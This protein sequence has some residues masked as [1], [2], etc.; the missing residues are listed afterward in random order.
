[1]TNL[2][3]IRQA[4]IKANPEIMELKFGCRIKTENMVKDYIKVICEPFKDSEKNEYIYATHGQTAEKIYLKPY[5]TENKIIK[6]LG[7]EIRLSDVLLA[8]EKL[9]EDR[10]SYWG[11][12]S[13]GEFIKFKRYDI[14]ENS[15]IFWDLKNDNL[16][17]QSE[18][19]I[20]FLVELLK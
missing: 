10:K 6:I 18:E 20:N 9:N 8:L 7:R 16:E 5:K 2:E 4:C 19:T 17:L 14:D 12:D 15:N 3:T 1:M 11:I 13:E